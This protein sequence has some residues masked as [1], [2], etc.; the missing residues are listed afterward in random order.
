MMLS[1]S[2]LLLI[3][4]LALL[5][6]GVRAET[7]A[8]AAAP[9]SNAEGAN[10]AA[11]ATTTSEAEAEEQRRKATLEKAYAAEQQLAQQLRGQLTDSE[12]LSLR[13]SENGQEREV[14]AVLKPQIKGKALGAVLLLHGMNA[15][16]DWPGVIAPLRRGLPEA[17]WHTLSLQLP[18]RITGQDDMAWLDITRLRIAAALAELDG[19]SMKHIVIIGHD[20]G[21]VAAIDY[22]SENQAPAVQGLVVISLDG[23]ANEERRLDAARGLG[24]LKLPLLDIYAER[25]RPAVVASAT[26]RYDLARRN[27]DDKVEPRP[28]YSDIAKDYSRSKGLGMSYRQIK[29]VGTD[30]RYHGQQ[31][32]LV[33]RVRGWLKHYVK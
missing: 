23:R 24:Q 13:S 18:H 31:A 27:N 32:I 9:D 17:G 15:H 2:L 14:L 20:L 6:A 1:R 10:A 26:R 29:L 11:E 30:Y 28:S 8:D 21:A 25:D 4:L 12:L 16:P 33:K 7:A 22:L 3:P 19:R 5:A